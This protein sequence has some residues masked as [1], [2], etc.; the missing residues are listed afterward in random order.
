MTLHH[1]RELAATH[2]SQPLGTSHLPAEG[3]GVDLGP[4]GY[5]EREF[6]ATGTAGRYRHR[7]GVLERTGEQPYVTRVLVRAP[8]PEHFNGVV[9]A[10]P[11]HPDYDTATTWRTAY[12]WITD[13]CAAWVG[14]TQDHRMAD[15]M[16]QDFDP[17][18]YGELSIP[19]AGLRWDIVG[20]VLTALRTP[21]RSALTDLAGRVRYVYLSGWSNTGSFCRVFLRDFHQRHRLA[22]GAPAVDGYL[23]GIS[24]GAA[25]EAG[26]PPLDDDSPVLPAD[27]PRRVIGPTDV[28]VFEVLSELESETH[29]PALREDS[30]A[31]GDRYRLY[32]VAGTSHDNGQPR[33]VLTNHAQFGHRGHRLSDRRIAEQLSDARLDAV[34][35][36]AYALLHRWVA[37]GTPAPRAERFP[38]ADPAGSGAVQELARDAR[39]NVRGGVRTPWVEAPL[40]SYHPHSTPVPGYC[41]PSPWAP[42]GTAE[43]VARMIG[44]MTPLPVEELRGLYPTRKDYLDRYEASCTHLTGQ[45]LLLE[46]DARL[47]MSE[48]RDR[49][50]PHLSDEPAPLPHRSHDKAA[51]TAAADEKG[52]CS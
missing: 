11:L 51:D 15:A 36:A 45:G 26:Y 21:E 20:D 38:F 22:G 2:A 5:R 46:R 32:Q 13:T 44:H 28:P 10:E 24:S 3:V 7:E 6:L 23:I 41:V 19:A 4:L 27:D 18:R 50:L 40:A 33:S 35:R 8:S 9:V 37:T 43:M 52:P 16:R 29:R 14:I 12:P 39:G 17:E 49:P 47:L 30:D 31:P 48:A 42:M 34:A 25:G 1:L